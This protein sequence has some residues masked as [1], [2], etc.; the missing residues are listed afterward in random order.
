MIRFQVFMFIDFYRKSLQYRVSQYFAFNEP[1]G[2]L[3]AKQTLPLLW[4]LL[5]YSFGKLISFT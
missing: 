4:N 3:Q 2:P 1:N 5:K